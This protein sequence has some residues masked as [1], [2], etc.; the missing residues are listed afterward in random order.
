MM[1]A[2]CALADRWEMS[3]T[4]LRRLVGS[5]T[6][7]SKCLRGLIEAGLIKR[8]IQADRYRSVRYSLTEKGAEVAKLVKELEKLL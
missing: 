5:P 2:L 7:T 1:R 8:E 3:F 4:D 6:T